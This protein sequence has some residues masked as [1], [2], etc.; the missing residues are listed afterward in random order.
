VDEH[1]CESE[2]IIETQDHLTYYCSPKKA[3][4][5]LSDSLKKKTSFDFLDLSGLPK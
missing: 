4:P 1:Y 2:N 3:L 5:G